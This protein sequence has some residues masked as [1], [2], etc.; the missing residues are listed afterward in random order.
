MHLQSTIQR[1]SPL[2]FFIVNNLFLRNIKFENKFIFILVYTITIILFLINKGFISR[3]L[4]KDIFTYISKYTYSIFIAHGLVLFH[5]QNE[6]WKT[7]TYF[8][9]THLI[10]NILLAFFASIICGV[11]M[12]HFIEKPTAK[13]LNE[14]WK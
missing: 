9:T 4:N 6:F 2:I 11:L 14:H 1:G 12:Y 13:Y 7:H 10:L 3:A 8:L 5:L